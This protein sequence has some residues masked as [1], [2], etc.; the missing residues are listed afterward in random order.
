[1]PVVILLAPGT[2]RETVEIRPYGRAAPLRLRA[3]VGGAA[4]LSGS[5]VM[6]APQVKAGRITLEHAP[7]MSLSSIPRGW[8]AN[9]IGAPARWREMV[10]LAGEPLLQVE[11]HVQL[12]PGRFLADRSSGRLELAL[13]ERLA[14]TPLQIEVSHRAR[15]LTV[16]Q[17]EDVEITGLVFQ[18]AASPI[19][20]AAVV[21]EGAQRVRITDSVFRAN[22]AIGLAVRGSREVTLERNVL[23][24]NGEMGLSL[25]RVARLVARDNETS[26]NNWRGERGGY[27]GWSSAGMKASEISD[28]VFER[29]R[30]LANRTYGL[31]FDYDVT[32]VTMRD[33]VI[34]DNLRFGLVVEAAQGPVQVVNSRI[35]RNADGGVLGA[36]A[37]GLRLVHNA[38]VCNGRRQIYVSG[39]LDRAVTDGATG[40]TLVLNNAV[41]NVEANLLAGRTRDERL[42]ETTLPLDR[43]NAFL[44]DTRRSGNSWQHPAGTAGFALPARAADWG[45]RDAA[46]SIEALC[47]EPV[48][49]AGTR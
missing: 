32:N 5:D 12:Q 40:T 3:A 26:A 9:E 39:Q 2:Y 7:V 10:F 41:W 48:S 21:I 31:W 1:V 37:R 17:A 20:D 11:R 23:N 27:T 43:W 46:L 8:P 25:W 19:A 30:A 29:H 16:A 28:V 35:C 34:C 49:A 6:H 44:R 15:L 22:N 36:E 42:V 33:S 13:P 45:V 18:H 24:G 14:G 4:V 47:A 38:I